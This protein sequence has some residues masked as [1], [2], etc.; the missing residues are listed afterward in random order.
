MDRA[1]ENYLPFRSPQRS[2]GPE[3]LRL[4]PRHAQCLYSASESTS[5]IGGS[6]IGGRRQL[7][8]PPPRRRSFGTTEGRTGLRLP[9]TTATDSAPSHPSPCPSFGASASVQSDTRS[10]TYTDCTTSTGSWAR[11]GLA[12][13]SSCSLRSQC[14][15]DSRAERCHLRAEFPFGAC[16]RPTP[17]LRTITSDTTL[18]ERLANPD[19]RAAGRLS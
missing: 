7:Q 10:L 17:V 9:P 4:E 14:T 16:P 6:V 18:P 19:R 2:L 1:L 11:A 15:T 5:E 13:T 8:R 3:W 12:S